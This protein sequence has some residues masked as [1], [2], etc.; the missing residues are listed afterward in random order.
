[1]ALEE[2]RSR[3]FLGPG[4]LSPQVAHAIGF[5]EAWNAV[6]SG[7]PTAAADV[8]S[9]GG[10]PALPLAMRWPATMWLLIETAAKRAA[11][12]AEAVDRLELRDRV[13]VAND[14]A[15]R[16]G[17]HPD[18]RGAFELV[19]ARSLGL[20]A[21]AAELG[22]PLLRPGGL[23]VVSEP[24]GGDANRWPADGLGALGLGPALMVTVTAGTFAVITCQSAAPD[25]F[26]RKPG[27]PAKRPLF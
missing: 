20:P 8:G 15:E 26:P 23:M 1:V 27:L 12:L 2:A 17:R 9:G 22:A 19:T 25:R 14:R 3:G 11:F 16:V 21:I 6:R 4:P 5:A 13:S 10:V 7:P 24:P 18:R